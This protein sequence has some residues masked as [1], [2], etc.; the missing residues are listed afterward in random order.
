MKTSI[1]RSLLEDEN[2]AVSPTHSMLEDEN[3]HHKSVPDI[4]S[5]RPVGFASGKNVKY[6]FG[7]GQFQ[8]QAQSGLQAQAW[9]TGRSSYPPGRD[10]VGFYK[11]PTI[12][13]QY[14]QF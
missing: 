12:Y 1:T 14:M 6:F 13:R 5:T 3:I 9:L 2:V 10:I 4:A 8:V 7:L 11:N